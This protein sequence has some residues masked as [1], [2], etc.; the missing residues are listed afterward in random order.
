M[1]S[2]SGGNDFHGSGFWY[3]QRAALNSKDQISGIVPLGDA[4]TF[5][6]SLGGPIVLPHIY[7]GKNKTFF[8]FDYE[9]VRL[10]ATSLISTNTIPL[11]WRTG[12]LSGAGS[13][14]LDTNGNPIPGNKIPL[15]MLNPVALKLIP[16]LF[17]NPTNSENSLLAPNPPNL[18]Q[19]F[20]GTYNN[21][22]FDGRLDQSF[23]P[24]H[25]VWGRVTQKTISSIGT[26]AA[27]GAGG[28]GDASYN[29]LMGPFTTDS[30]LTNVAISYNW[31]IKVNLV[32]ELRFG[33]TRANFT[34]SYPEA[35]EGNT[36][37]SSAG[38]EGLPGPP[39]NGLG[40]VPVFYM[41][42]ISGRPDQ[43]LRPP[44]REQEQNY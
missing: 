32:N 21:D 34:F 3:F 27:L 15:A 29:P 40:G 24:N 44:A 30:D 43:S 5:G 11:A 8:Y 28:A 22:G 14:V 16:Y 25:K 13:Q 42:D 17:P 38:I 39:K 10:N 23:G 4:N 12:D 1:I 41:G 2:R 19:P 31:I 35:A 9:G 20:P 37:V 26:D 33:Y 7:N 18:V 36:I 6:V